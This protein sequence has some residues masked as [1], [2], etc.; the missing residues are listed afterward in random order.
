MKKNNKKP[1][2]APWCFR[3]GG[4][5]NGDALPQCEIAFTHAIFWRKKKSCRLQWREVRW[6]TWE[7]AGDAVTRV[8]DYGLWP[9]S[10]SI[11]GGED[12][13]DA[14]GCVSR[15]GPHV[16]THVTCVTRITPKRHVTYFCIVFIFYSTFLMNSL[17]QC[18]PKVR[19]LILWATTVTS[20][21]HRILLL[22]LLWISV[23][24]RSLND[25]QLRP[26]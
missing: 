15:V 18:E 12:A 19:T 17:Q 7:D 16:G 24:S 3:P 6:R 23:H 9:G 2:S 14:G 11:N 21:C 20:L 13:E 26:N 22:L 25:P 4:R 10:V 5:K 8:C 1:N